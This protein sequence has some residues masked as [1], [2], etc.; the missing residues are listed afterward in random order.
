MDTRMVLKTI[1]L[2]LKYTVQGR[3]GIKAAWEVE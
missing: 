3:G 1:D 2:Q